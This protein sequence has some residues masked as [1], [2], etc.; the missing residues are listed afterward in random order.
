[1]QSINTV[2]SRNSVLD[3]T[4]SLLGFDHVG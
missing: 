2:I 3:H 4:K 1:M